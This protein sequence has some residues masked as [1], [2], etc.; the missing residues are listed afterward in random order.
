MENHL[1]RDEFAYEAILG[2]IA[3]R[4]FE[5]GD[6]ILETE[7]A[8]SLDLSRTPVREALSRLVAENVLKKRRKKGYYIPKT[9][10]D[11]ARKIFDARIL[12]EIHFAELAAQ[13]A[14]PEQITEMELILEHD[15][16]ASA[17]HDKEKYS[18]INDDFHTAIAIA[19]GNEYLLK[20]WRSVYFRSRIYTLLRDQFYLTPPGGSPPNQVTPREH[21]AIFQAIKAGDPQ[22]AAAAMKRHLQNNFVG[23]QYTP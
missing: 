17:T 2:M 1:D 11:D 14:T 23:L 18:R 21:R 10:E 6:V 4:A 9:S 3:D 19:S 5:P 20:C 22:R 16:V 8:R 13:N 15:S 12:L 7:I